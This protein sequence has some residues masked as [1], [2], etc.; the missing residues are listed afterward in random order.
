MRKTKSAIHYA[1]HD[2]AKGML[3]VGVTDQVTFPQLHSW[4]F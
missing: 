1:V 3:K 2:A 4:K